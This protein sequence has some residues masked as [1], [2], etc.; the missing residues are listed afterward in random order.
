MMPNPS[1][2]PIFS[3]II[4]ITALMSFSLFLLFPGL[5]L[6]NSEASLAAGKKERTLLTERVVNHPIFGEG[7][8]KE[9]RI[10]SLNVWNIMF[11]WQVRMQRVKEMIE[12]LDCDI[13]M[14]QEVVENR[15]LNFFANDPQFDY[16]FHKHSDSREGLAIIWKKNLNKD[17]NHN[18]QDF[19]RLHTLA[20]NPHSPDKNPRILL[21]VR[22]GVDKRKLDVYVTHLTYD[23]SLQC[24]HANEIS[25][26]IHQNKQ[27]DNIFKEGNKHVQWILGGDLNIYKDHPYP[28]YILQGI[29]FPQTQHNGCL[30]PNNDDSTQQ[31][32]HDTWEYLHHDD[33][34]YTFSNMPTPGLESRPDRIIMEFE[35]GDSETSTLNWIPDTISTLSGK[36]YASDYY[37][38][39]L[40]A[41]LK[42]MGES[43]NESK[44]TKAREKGSDCLFDCGPRGNC[45]CGVCVIKEEY[46][47]YQDDSSGHDY[48][49]LGLTCENLV[50]KLTFLLGL[51][52]TF[53]LFSVWFCCYCLINRKRKKTMLGIRGRTLQ[54]L[55]I[56]TM[57]GG[58]YVF[59]FQQPMLLEIFSLE[60]EFKIWLRMLP[61][62][63]NVSDHH[64]L[65]L[66]LK[67]I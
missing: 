35:G 9:L 65:F 24:Q 17:E 63:L 44:R 52:V 5:F 40:W 67:L 26:I 55:G 4:L 49:I 7:H 12:E 1:F 64:A 66:L 59:C 31:T 48:E 61:E 2:P 32:A 16:I 46:Y 37:S 36:E 29:P 60:K 8:Q 19:A 13:I 53:V 62:E 38:L 14:L 6:V 23:R 3:L 27:M 50:S 20:Y 34:G 58:F 11:N 54:L 56:M 33:T 22:L 25:D 42:M 57:L 28:V 30:S 47:Q 39:I 21:G 45:I 18:P 10:L 51:L 41:R 43:G 15:H